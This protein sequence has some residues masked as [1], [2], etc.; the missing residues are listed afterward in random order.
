MAKTTKSLGQ[1][2]TLD[3]FYTKESIAIYCLSKIN[4]NEYDL[5]IEPSA[6]NGSFS[7]LIPNCKAYDIDPGNDKIIKQDWFN[8][9]FPIG[10]ILVVGNPPFGQQN[11]LAIKF[12]NHA[13]EFARTIAFIFPLSFKKQSIQNKLDLS[14]S[15]QEEFILPLDSFLLNNQ[16]YNVPCV[17]QIWEKT[18]EKRKIIKQKTTTSLF[19]F[20]SK[21][22]ADLR[23]QRV[24]GNAG[25][26]STNL[27]VAESSNYFIKLNGI[28]KENFIN[29][30]NSISFPSIGFT[31]GPR[32]LSKSELIEEIEKFYE[33]KN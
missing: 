4:L 5:V 8:T 15:L 7:N 12:F 31:V 3:K 20:V 2:E 14:F 28:E 1:K 19:S 17:F 27:D 21:K 22:E 25:K 23:I 33:G 32:S 10:N 9:N 11:S 26:A 13:A 24:G 30:I 29:L 18:K 6:G 16:N